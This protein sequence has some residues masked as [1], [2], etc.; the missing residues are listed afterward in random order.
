MMIEKVAR[1]IA[2]QDGM[3]DIGQPLPLYSRLARA[4]IEALAA[5][6]TDE[7]VEAA[8]QTLSFSSY[9]DPWQHPDI[10]RRVVS[11]SLRAA[12]S[13]DKGE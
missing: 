13:E 10:V 7:M 8:Q 5:N 1:A 3:P 2:I 12:L 6:V 4:A 11:A 9:P